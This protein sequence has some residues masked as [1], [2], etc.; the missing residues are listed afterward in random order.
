MIEAIAGM[1]LETPQTLTEPKQHAAGRQ[2]QA[3]PATPAARGIHSGHD[4]RT[5]VNLRSFIH[6]ALVFGVGP[7]QLALPEAPIVGKRRGGPGWV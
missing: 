2:I 6:S 7:R 3:L 5:S 4:P 1:M